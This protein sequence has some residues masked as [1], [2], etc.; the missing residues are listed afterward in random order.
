LSAVLLS[1][2]S[3]PTIATG[4]PSS[5]SAPVPSAAVLGYQVVLPVVYKA[6]F[7]LWWPLLPGGPWTRCVCEMH[8]E[9]WCLSSLSQQEIVRPLQ[10]AEVKYSMQL[11][12]VEDTSASGLR[13]ITPGY[14]TVIHLTRVRCTSCKHLLPD[15]VGL[16]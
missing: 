14:P 11:L 6:F 8:Q 10:Q 16:C 4:M 9:E 15:W 5:S 2:L 1:A 13:C 7:L 3:V 12:C